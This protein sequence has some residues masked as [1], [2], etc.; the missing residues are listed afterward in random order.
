MSTTNIATLKQLHIISIRHN[1]GMPWTW[2]TCCFIQYIQYI[3]C[4]VP[5]T[6]LSAVG[7]TFSNS[8]NVTSPFA[9]VAHCHCHLCP[10]QS[11][12]IVCISWLP[13]CVQNNNNHKQ[14]R[15]LLHNLYL[16]GSFGGCLFPSRFDKTPQ[17]RGYEKHR[18]AL[19][20]QFIGQLE[21]Y[22]LSNVTP[23]GG[24]AAA[25]VYFLGRES[26]D[27]G[28]VSCLFWHWSSSLQMWIHTLVNPAFITSDRRAKEGDKPVSATADAH[29]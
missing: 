4:N 22:R 3:E 5:Q 23:S 9:C 10:L 27:I 15:C 24:P 25:G 21:Q 20:I 26:I 19:L 28:G 8:K 1:V 16:K 29:S 14:H 12:Q 17:T 7:F 11:V 6:F 13:L 18:L 2:T